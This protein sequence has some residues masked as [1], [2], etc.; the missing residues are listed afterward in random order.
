MQSPGKSEIEIDAAAGRGRGKEHMGGRPPFVYVKLAQRG[1]AGTQRGQRYAG[2]P[3]YAIPG[4]GLAARMLG[5]PPY[6]APPYAICGPGLPARTLGAP[7]PPYAPMLGAGLPV[8]I[9]GTPNGTPGP[10]LPA[11]SGAIG[12]ASPSVCGTGPAYGS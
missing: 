12:I 6:A 4:P 7:A 2:A 11:R 10:G 5:A 3:P 1:E 9:G 8:R